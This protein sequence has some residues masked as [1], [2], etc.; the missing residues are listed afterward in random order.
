MLSPVMNAL[1]FNNGYHTIHHDKP[2]IH[3]SKLPEAHAEIHD[4]IHPALYEY[5]FWWFLIRQY[6]LAPFVPALRRPSMREERLAREAAEQ[7]GA[8]AGVPELAAAE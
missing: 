8:P 1:L 5:S 2:G 4:N 6:L 3:W 7:N